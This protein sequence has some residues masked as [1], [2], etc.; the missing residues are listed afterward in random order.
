MGRLLNSHYNMFD[1]NFEKDFIP[2]E[3]KMRYD[4]LLNMQPNIF[5]DIMDVI[6]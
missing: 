5:T 3:I 4:R 1:I 6:N 2:E